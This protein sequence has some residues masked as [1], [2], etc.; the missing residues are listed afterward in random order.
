MEP[1]T[2]EYSV[3][4]ILSEQWALFKITHSELKSY[5][6]EAI[7]KM[8]S[9]G[10]AGK[11]FFIYY[12]DTCDKHYTT[13]YRCNSRA[14]N[15]C[16]KFYADE[17]AE[18]VGKKTFNKV[19][20][21]MTFTIPED[22]RPLFRNRWDLIKVMSDSVCETIRLVMQKSSHQ[23]LT[24]AL[25]AVIHPFGK[26]LKFHP[27]IHTLVAEG[28]LNCRGEWK[29]FTYFH[30]ETLRKTWQDTLIKRLTIITEKETDSLERLNLLDGMHEAYPNGFV[31]DYGGGRKRSKSK[32]W[33]SRYIGRYLRH[34]PISDRRIEHYDSRQVTF[35]HETEKNNRRH[36]TLT[37]EE[38]LN[39]LIQHIP[40]KSFKMVRYYGLYNRKDLKKNKIRM[41]QETITETIERINYSKRSIKCPTCGKRLEPIEYFRKPPPKEEIFGEKL[42]DWIR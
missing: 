9:C 1:S 30:H 18:K 2:T 40:P 26:D 33:I 34:L 36:V 3:R 5:Q 24:P 13:H 41:K 4:N 12:C 8:L 27:H 28:G 7:D 20:R 42:T 11:G 39:R 14:C 15:R 16:G 29:D 22:L 32:K 21:H 38:F 23:E 17:W 25:V 35:W 31:V 10:D 37:V 19:H 6:T